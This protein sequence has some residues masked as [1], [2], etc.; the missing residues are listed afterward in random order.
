MSLVLNTGMVSNL[1]KREINTIFTKSISRVNKHLGL[2]QKITSH[3]GSRF[4]LADC[5]VKTP[6]GRQLCRAPEFLEGSRIKIVNIHF[7]MVS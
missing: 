7:L 1:R 4:I 6:H 5:V 3:F 2:T